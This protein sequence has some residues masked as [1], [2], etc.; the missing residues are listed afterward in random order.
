M[1]KAT[2]IKVVIGVNGETTFEVINGDGKTCTELTKALEDSVGNITN[3]DFKPEHRSR[4]TP[5][6]VQTKQTPR[7]TN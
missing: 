6:T 1:A 5:G 2:Q 7:L 3:R 4:F